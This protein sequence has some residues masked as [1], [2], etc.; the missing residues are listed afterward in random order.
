M[1]RIALMSLSLGVVISTM[2]VANQPAHAGRYR[3]GVNARQQR[4]QDR[5]AN[6]ISSGSLTARESARLER[7]QARLNNQ[8]ARYR[9][10]GGGLS[11]Q[12]RARLESEQN[13]LSQNIYNQKHDAQGSYG[14]LPGN[15]YR[16]GVNARQENQQD[17]I[18]QGVQSG[19]L[20]QSEY[21]RLD[22]QEE[23]LATQE[24]RMRQSGDGLSPSER[25][26]LEAEQNALS[27]HIY[28]QKHDGQTE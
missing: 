26:R 6:G 19:Q 22:N 8:E 24:A 9:A 21:G 27:R 17:R 1:N 3:Y 7:Q 23:R 25:A 18:Y 11:P 4:Q 15:G 12:E 2:V 14:G 10:S 5:I 20:T 13:R 16:M 28:N